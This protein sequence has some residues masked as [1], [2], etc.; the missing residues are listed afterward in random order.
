M[1]LLRSFTRHGSMSVEPAPDRRMTEP[2][3]LRSPTP[4][5][6]APATNPGAFMTNGSSSYKLHVS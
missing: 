1:G 3:L 6:S 5:S 4:P 2:S